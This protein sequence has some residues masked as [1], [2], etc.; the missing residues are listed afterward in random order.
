MRIR[1]EAEAG[2][3]GAPDQALA[4]PGF[5]HAVAID[6]DGTLT[7]DGRPEAETLA[8]LDE[9]RA[10]G[11]RIIIVTGRIL[12]ELLEVFPDAGEHVDAIIAENGAVLAHD[13]RQRMLAPPVPGE[14]ATALEARGVAVRRG[15]ALLACKGSDDAVVLGE[16]RRLGLD[17]QLVR[18][19][20]ELM[21]LPA[22]VS[23]GTGLASGLSDLGISPH[24]AVAIGDA[25]NDH[26]LLLAAEL[27][28]AV[29]NAVPALK[30][31]ADVVLAEPDG[32]RSTQARTPGK[33]RR[34]RSTM[35]STGAP[36]ATSSW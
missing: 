15:Q 19:R 35:P 5:F 6:F 27:G 3:R 13:G 25:E 18:N 33:Q 34:G 14:L 26:S 17:C 29:G 2:A 28:V 1:P 12:A 20:G 30:A 23:K 16:V 36:A 32:R 4:G 31:D 21:V 24:S 9:A 8:A 22:G 11:R 10:A 7:M